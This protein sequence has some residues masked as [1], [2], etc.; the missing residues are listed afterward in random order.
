M[1]PW[2]IGVAAVAIVVGVINYKIANWTDF[3]N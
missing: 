2:V 1:L 3:K